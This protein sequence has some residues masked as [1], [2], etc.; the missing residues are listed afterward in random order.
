MAKVYPVQWRS[1]AI[2]ALVT[3]LIFSGHMVLSQQFHKHCRSNL[4]KVLL[5]GKS[6][7]CVVMSFILND[8]E[9]LFKS[10]ISQSVVKL[11]IFK[12]IAL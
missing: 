1:C 12:W 5:Y 11:D 10:V 2:I 9:T 4:L 8:T 7:M 6:D 3:F